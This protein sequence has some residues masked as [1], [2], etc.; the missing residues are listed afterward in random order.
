MNNN[1]TWNRLMEIS[2]LVGTAWG[3]SL[4]ASGDCAQSFAISKEREYA[5][6]APAAAACVLLKR[7]F[8]LLDELE[9]LM[10]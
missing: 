6:R 2:G 10:K 1:D 3:L 5:E 8:E 7:A 9:P 4:L